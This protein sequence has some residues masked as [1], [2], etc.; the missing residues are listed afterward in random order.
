MTFSD[1]QHKH[2]TDETAVNHTTLTPVDAVEQLLRGQSRTPHDLL[3]AHLVSHDGVDGVVVRARSVHASNMYVVLGDERLPMQ[4]EFGELFTLF[5]P[6]AVLPMHYRLCSERVDGT[7]IE[8]DD[9]YRFTPTL[10][11]V[12]LHLFG[13]GRHLRLWE[14]LGAHLRVIDGVEGTSFAVWAPNATRVSVIGSFN[15]WDGRAHVM[16]LLGSSGVFELFVPGV[17]AE[18]IYKFEIRSPT[19]Q[20]RVKTD[21]FAAKMEQAPGFASVVQRR[22][23]HEWRDGAWLAKRTDADPAREPM[24]VYEVHLASWMRGEA[25]RLLTYTELAPR[26]AAHVKR[27]GFTHVELLPIQEHPFGGSWGYQVG[28]YFAPTSRHGSPDD[29]RA[30]VDTLH[31]AGIGVLLD[32]VPAHFPKDDWALRRF[33]GTAV[34]EHEDPRLGDHPEWGTHIF[35]YARHEVRNFLLANALYWIEEFHIDGLRVD[36]V[37]SMLYLDYGREAGQWLRNR[38]GGRENLEA[39]S[40]LKSLNHTVHTLHPGVVTIAEESTTWPKVTHPIAEGGLGFTFKW[41]MGWMHDTLDYFRVDPFFRKGAHNKLTFAMMYEYSERFMNPLSH[42]EVVHLKKSLLEK[43]PGDVWQRFANLRASI[44]YAVTRPGKSLLFMGTE[45]A[46]YREWNHDQ[47]LDWH[48]ADDP[49]RVGVDAFMQALGEMYNANSC[50]WRC[51]HEPSGFAWI[52]VDDREQSVLSYARF[53]GAQ[54]AVVVL[55]LTP[56]PRVGYRMGAPRAGAYRYVLNSDAPEFGGSGYVDIDEVTTEDIP[57][58]GF[59]QSVV[60]KLPPLSMVVLFPEP[61]VVVEPVNEAVDA[62][63]DLD[64]AKDV[65][66]AIDVDS[67]DA[68]E[69]EPTSDEVVPIRKGKRSKAAKPTKEAKAEKPA[70]AAKEAK[71]PKPPKAPKNSDAPK[72]SKEEKALKAAARRAKEEQEFLAARAEAIARA[73]ASALAAAERAAA[74]EQASQPVKSSARSKSVKSKAKS[75]AKPRVART[76]RNSPDEGS[77]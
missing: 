67:V 57:C 21:P 23:E 60:L 62:A 7:Q 58:H 22:G 19:G 43:M 44:G 77:A 48:L 49:R 14:K 17:D 52:S 64:A 66:A 51:D 65:D 25:N 54:H 76:P 59:A 31:E 68:T 6:G 46:P 13:E 26:L 20:I 1:S 53:D 5:L 8:Y 70:R 10:G 69:K 37:A 42:D 27:L 73:E 45:L 24:H 38:L 50:F 33:D 11:D 12:D 36:A 71:A 30:F 29:F 34:Y 74:A 75:A 18:S 28:G 15:G 16:R 61:L 32:W 35:N 56:V 63:I 39:A 40:F 2:A 47:S 9:A 4:R 55:N 72:L 3:G 41:N